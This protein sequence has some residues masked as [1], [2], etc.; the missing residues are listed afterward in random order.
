MKK[1]FYNTTDFRQLQKEW[2]GKLRDEGF[3][4]IEDGLDN[5]RLTAAKGQAKLVQRSLKAEHVKR[6]SKYG[7]RERFYH[8]AGRVAAAAFR[9]GADPVTCYVWALYAD[10]VGDRGI[11]NNIEHFGFKLSKYRVRKLINKL[12]TLVDKEI[13][14]GI[15]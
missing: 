3:I 8:H 15:G 10:G 5:A 12:F 1:R 7:I 9:Q 2:Y 14:D 6:K 11:V 13:K 4:D